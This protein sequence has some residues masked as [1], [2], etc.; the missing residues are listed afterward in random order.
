MSQSELPPSYVATGNYIAMSSSELT[1]HKGELL[2]RIA[3]DV[4]IASSNNSFG[5]AAANVPVISRP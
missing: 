4:S 1:V 2:E 5:Y 3:S